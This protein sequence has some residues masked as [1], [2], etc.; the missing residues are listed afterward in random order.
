M[1]IL[2]NYAHNLYTKAQLKNCTTG[3]EIGGFDLIIKYKFEHIDSNF[4]IKNK[5]ILDQKRGAG[6]WLWKPYFIYKTM[7][8]RMTDD[9]VLYYCD[10]GHY[11]YNSIDHYIPHMEKTE[12]KFL[13]FGT[14]GSS[15]K[16]YTKRDVLHYMNVDNDYYH[17]KNKTYEATWF[18]LK[19]N[20]FT[21]NFIKEWLEYSQDYR[22]I[23]DSF[24]ECGLPNY[25]EFIDHRHDQSI[26]N[27]LALKYNL[28]DPLLMSH[29]YN[30][31]NTKTKLDYQI[32]IYSGRHDTN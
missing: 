18:L 32:M 31:G 11:F 28:E 21:L 5:N 26:F 2:I 12:Q 19:K 20:K 10:A 6:Y 24:N 22:L 9:D 13:T 25:P 30:Y 1:K 15:L 3:L 16:N 17:S 29:Q 27:I 23:T 8:E 14:Q 4:Y 7:V